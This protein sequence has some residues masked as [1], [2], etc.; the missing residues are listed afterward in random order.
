MG[1]KESKLFKRV[2]KPTDRKFKFEGYCLYCKKT[3]FFRLAGG[4]LYETYYRCMSCKQEVREKDE[5]ETS[6]P[7]TE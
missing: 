4:S 6:T 2:D 7:P 3:R 5:Y 1:K